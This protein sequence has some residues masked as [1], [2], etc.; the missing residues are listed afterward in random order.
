MAAIEN[1][2]IF[3]MKMLRRRVKSLKSTI[4]PFF[5]GSWGWRCRQIYFTCPAQEM[6]TCARWMKETWCVLQPYLPDNW[7][8][9]DRSET[10]SVL[11]T[12][13]TGIHLIHDHRYR[14]ASRR[15]VK[16]WSLSSIAVFFVYLRP[17][18]VLIVEYDMSFCY[19]MGIDTNIMVCKYRV[20]NKHAKLV[21]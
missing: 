1:K 8:P 17:T 21:K 6:Y 4:Q 18:R 20:S 16:T 2:T 7:L 14:H 11:V 10:L 19:L 15:F 5:G 12:L 3:A 9:K 13:I